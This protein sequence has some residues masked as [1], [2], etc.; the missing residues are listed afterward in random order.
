MLVVFI[1]FVVFLIIGMPIAFAIGISGALY[2]LQHLNLPATIMV[3]LPLTQ[4]QNFSLL[5][6]PLFI[7]AG[8]LL[9]CGGTTDRLAK[10]AGILTGRMRGG[11]AQTSVVLSTMMGGVSGSCIAD[12]AMEAR[13]LGTQMKKEGYATG[14]IACNIAFTGLITATVPPGNAMIIFGTTGNVSIGKLF[15]TGMLVGVFMMVVMMVTTWAIS[16]LRGYK[17][18][19]TE[20]IPLRE[21][22]SSFK[23]CFW[24]LLFPVMLLVGIRFGLFT[25][26]EVG[27]F[28][29]VYAVFVGVFIYK[30]LNMKTF[31]KALEDTAKD[32]GAVMFIIALSAIFGY[33][34]PID[35][36]PQAVSGFLMGITTN[37]SLIL[38]MIILMLSMVGMFMEG[39]ATILILT[40]I[41]LPL[42]TSIGMDPVHFGMV[43]TT[44]IN[45]S[46]CTPPVGLSMYTVNSILGCSLNEYMKEMVP[47]LITF[48]IAVLFV[49][50]CPGAFMWLQNLLY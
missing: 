9:N 36:V 13:L 5:A 31:M 28:A 32:V 44:T 24:A 48:L 11:Y 47:W 43:M 7:F 10:F 21:I 42:A 2:F 30:E 38:L 35:R 37:K 40:P 33:G 26:S 17:P 19:R 46:N 16:C 41:L 23:E 29:C 20:K 18:S 34:V 50:Y 1:A 27:S 22:W 39:A 45:L 3:Q 4:A 6:V 25:P 12:A 49:A 14:F 15:T 8:N